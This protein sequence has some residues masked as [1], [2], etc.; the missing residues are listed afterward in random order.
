MKVHVSDPS[1]LPELVDD[2][3]RG[4]CVPS[5]VGER[6][7]EVIHPQAEDAKEARMELGLFLRAWQRAHPQVDVTVS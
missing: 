7:L 6:T 5:T 4:G 2:L 3:L 1:C